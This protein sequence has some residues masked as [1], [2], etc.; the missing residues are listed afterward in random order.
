MGSKRVRRRKLGLTNVDEVSSRELDASRGSPTY[1]FNQFK[2][3]ML[4]SLLDDLITLENEGIDEEI[5]SRV[6]KSLGFFVNSTTNVPSG[7]MFTGALSPRVQKFEEAYIKWNGINGNDEGAIKKRRD[8]LVK[9]R[10]LQQKITDKTRALQFELSNDLD[11]LVLKSGYEAI[12]EL[13]TV[14]PKLFQNLASS[15]AKFCSRGGLDFA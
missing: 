2:G 6:K 15:Y 10:K 1:A 12:S 5:C 7:G 4:S 11:V 3:N 13:I 8:V 14:S 9:M